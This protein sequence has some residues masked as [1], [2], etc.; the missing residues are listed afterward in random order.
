MYRSTLWFFNH[1]NRPWHLKYT[2]T[3]EVINFPDTVLYFKIISRD[4]LSDSSL[5][6]SSQGR[7][8]QKGFHLE[9]ALSQCD[10]V[11]SQDNKILISKYSRG[12]LRAWG[13]VLQANFVEIFTVNACICKSR[14]F[15]FNFQLHLLSMSRERVGRA[16]RI[17]IL[18]CGKCFL[19]RFNGGVYNRPPLF[20][21]I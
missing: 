9:L 13:R 7:S 11:K 16:G 19:L 8:M 15:I 2:S 18:N 17:K 3:E 6:E 21:I 10:I 4:I 20:D 5:L 14:A 1:F 12:I